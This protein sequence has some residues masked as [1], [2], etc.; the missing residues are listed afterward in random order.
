[1]FWEVLKGFSME[2]QKKFLKFVT[3]CSRGPLLGFR[4]LEPL[5]CIQRQRDCWVQY[6]DFVPC[7]AGGNASEDALDRLPTSA[8]CMN[9]LK[10]PPYRRSQE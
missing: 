6:S 9:L 7:R 10:L 1:M 5:F 8:T 3:G 4:Y 2:N